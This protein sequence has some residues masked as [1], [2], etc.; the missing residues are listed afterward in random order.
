MVITREFLD[1]GIKEG[2]ELCYEQCRILKIEYPQ[3]ENWRETVLGKKLSDTE[4]SEYLSLKKKTTVNP[5]VLKDMRREKGIRVSAPYKPHVEPL[6]NKDGTKVIITE[7]WLRSGMTSGIGIKNAQ[8]KVL[9]VNIKK[10]GWFIGLIG[11]EIPKE[12]ADKYISLK[13]SIP[14]KR[15]KGSKKA[16][17]T[18]SFIK[19]YLTV[20]GKPERKT[21]EGKMMRIRYLSRM[22][23]KKIVIE[24]IRRM[25][26]KEFLKTPY[27]KIISEFQK[28]ESDYCCVICGSKTNLNVHH[29][30]YKN[31]GNEA[32]NLED[33][34]TVCRDC[35]RKI[36]NLD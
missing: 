36:H 34:I 20:D 8:A 29:T 30:T 16:K 35:H 26:Y 25:P 12:V 22:Y 6:L 23:D 19:N 2:M 17:K 13:Y 5:E 24:Q 10:R 27:W 3:S 15:V 11:A 4:A 7:E 14:Q 33:L 31:H 21:V 9:G 32:L 28:Y 18:K 1:S